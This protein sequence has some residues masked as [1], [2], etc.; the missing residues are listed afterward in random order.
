M[1]NVINHVVT[2]SQNA[3]NQRNMSMCHHLCF[4]TNLNNR[5]RQSSKV[6]VL[7]VNKSKSDSALERVVR[8]DITL[9]YIA[10]RASKIHNAQTEEKCKFYP[11]SVSTILKK[12]YK[13][14]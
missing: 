5:L 1:T 9:E 12:T 2:C 10:S 13:I 4:K 8:Y 7:I 3:I 14:K 6:L 11:K